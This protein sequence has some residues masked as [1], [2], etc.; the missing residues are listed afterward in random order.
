MF[1]AAAIRRI[2]ATSLAEMP[3]ARAGLRALVAAS[4]C[5]RYSFLHASLIVT[6]AAQRR[7]R[8]NTVNA[9]L[10]AKRL[11]HLKNGFGKGLGRIGFEPLEA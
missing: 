1:L 10:P 5:A 8:F 7:G 11:K 6:F 2:F 4:D 3:F 9:Q